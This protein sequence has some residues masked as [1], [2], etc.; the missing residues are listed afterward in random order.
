MINE[1]KQITIAEVNEIL[2]ETGDEKEISV[3]LK[4]FSK[5]EE[6]QAKEFA[7]ELEKL[8][9]MKLK[10]EYIVKII[11]MLPEDSQDLNKIFIE[12]S[13]DEDEA[14]KIL[15]VVKKYR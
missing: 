10:R 4:K 14:A 15:E 7:E 2:K 3:F 5:I 6:E 13:L 12:V 9:I 1:M 8:E 11:D